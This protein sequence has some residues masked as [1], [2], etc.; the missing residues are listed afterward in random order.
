VAQLRKHI[1]DL[2]NV[3]FE[4]REAAAEAIRAMGVPALAEV[5]KHTDDADAEVADQCER[6]AEFL[7]LQI[8][9]RADQI[10]LVLTINPGQIKAGQNMQLMAQFINKTAK[11]VLIPGCANS[12]TADLL[13]ILQVTDPDGKPVKGFLARQAPD[14]AYVMVVPPHQQQYMHLMFIVAKEAAATPG[15]TSRPAATAYL[16]MSD[17][18][19]HIPLAKT[20]QYSVKLVLDPAKVSAEAQK[21]VVSAARTVMPDGSVSA[22][23]A[24]PF[25]GVLS[26]EAATFELAQ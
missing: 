3:K 5:L 18:I 10:E 25:T 26:S 16:S 9:A 2:G 1:A 23:K 19:L 24:L 7:D 13:E 8:P 11:P 20:G 6:I 14:S 17:R 21:R 12:S 4:V 22:Q 15:A